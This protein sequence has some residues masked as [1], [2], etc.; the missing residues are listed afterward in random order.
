MACLWHG[1][2]QTLERACKFLASPGCF[3][4]DVLSR[5]TACCM[6]NSFLLFAW[7]LAPTIFVSWSL[8][9]LETQPTLH[10]Y[11]SLCVIDD[12]IVFPVLCLTSHIFSSFRSPTL[13]HCSLYRSCVT[14]LLTF[15]LTLNLLLLLN[16]FHLFSFSGAQNCTEHSRCRY[17]MYL[18]SSTVIFLLYWLFLL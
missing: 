2:L 13:L 6:K 3:G 18:Y 5:S 8:T 1:P 10:P 15:N 9:V 7:N 12:I 4:K 11:P 17:K 14:P 16:L